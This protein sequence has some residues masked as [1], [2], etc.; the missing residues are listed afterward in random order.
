MSEKGQK[1]KSPL[2]RCERFN[3]LTNATAG[4]VTLRKSRGCPLLEAVMCVAFDTGTKPGSRV[5]PI[6]YFH[7]GNG[8]L[9]RG[10]VRIGMATPPE[11]SSVSA[12][13]AK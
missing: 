13:I 4:G 3:R 2:L 11:E 1:R 5:D 7:L 9:V 8:A 6:A 12:A 10:M